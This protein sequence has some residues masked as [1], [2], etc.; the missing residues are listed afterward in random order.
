MSQAKT[1]RVAYVLIYHAATFWSKVSCEL[2]NNVSFLALL[3]QPTDIQ[4]TGEALG[5]A[6]RHE[7][8]ANSHYSAED[9]SITDYNLFTGPQF[10]PVCAV[11]GGFIGQEAIKVGFLKVI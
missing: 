11:I 10:G 4:L 3:K 1:C 7:L 8:E 9:D 6:Y 5:D 2:F